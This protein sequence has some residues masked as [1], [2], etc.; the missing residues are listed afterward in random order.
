M[1]LL[2]VS[3]GAAAGAPLRFF[4]DR[5]VQARTGNRFPW[6]TFAVNVSGSLLLGLLAAGTALGSL[7]AGA[8]TAGGVG[9]CGAFTTYSAFGYQTLQL[10]GAGQRLAAVA[11]IALS[12]GCGLAAAW[13]GWRLALV[14]WS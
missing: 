13:A 14:V 9:F 3:L 11:N 6:G 12:L 2:L 10:A 5:A 4:L 1:T 8:L 7:P